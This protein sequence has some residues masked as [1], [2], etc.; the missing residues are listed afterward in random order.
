MCHP[1]QVR[2][3]LVSLEAHLGEAARQAG[4]LGAKEGELG[5]A[6]AAFGQVGGGGTGA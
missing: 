1:H 2:D 4:R 5:E 3:Y 6:L